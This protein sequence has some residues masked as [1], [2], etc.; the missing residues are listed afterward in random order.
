MKIHQPNEKRIIEEIDTNIGQGEQ[1][2]TNS[3]YNKIYVMRR[4]F[5]RIT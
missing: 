5:L 2:K 4:N 1:H 3:I